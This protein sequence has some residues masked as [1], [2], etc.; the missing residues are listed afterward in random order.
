MT[1]VL[2]NNLI[3][4]IFMKAPHPMLITKAKDGT[5]IDIN[6][7]AARYMKMKREK[8]IGHT[9]Q[10]VGHIQ[11]EKR[12]MVMNAIKEKGYVSN[13]DLEVNIR[14]KNILYLIFSTFPINMGEDTFFLTVITDIL[15]YKSDIEKRRE[16]TLLKLT[17]QNA[18][19]CIK[20]NLR[21]YSLTPRQREVALLAAF[22][23]SNGEIAQKMLISKNTVKEYI[24]KVYEEIGV[25]NRCEICPRILNWR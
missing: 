13:V 2:Q 12:L 24:K 3:K 5:Y 10:E 1:K 18:A 20:A 4:T 14:R 7:A 8:V 25:H 22:G 15:Q 23:H 16:G 11:A 19:L 17:R 21:Q 6:E 9:T